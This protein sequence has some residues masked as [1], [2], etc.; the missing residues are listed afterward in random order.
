MTDIYIYMYIYICQGGGAEHEAIQKPK[1]EKNIGAPLVA[2]KC[3][4]KFEDICVKLLTFV[5]IQRDSSNCNFPMQ[6]IVMN[7]TAV[8]YHCVP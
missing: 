7:L 2:H 3:A 4:K 5:F 6:T 8:T 1:S